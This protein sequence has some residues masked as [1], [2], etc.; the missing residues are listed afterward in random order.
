MY[1]V[2]GSIQEEHTNIWT[3]NGEG[4]GLERRNVPSLAAY[5]FLYLYNSLKTQ[6]LK[7]APAFGPS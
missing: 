1:L 4:K 5:L 3:G 2:P 6:T 7:D